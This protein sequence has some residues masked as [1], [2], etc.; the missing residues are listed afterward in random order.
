MEKYHTTMSDLFEQL[1]LASED[2]D[3]EQF[4]SKHKGLRQGVHIEDADFWSRQQAE[5]IRSSLLEDAE[6]AELIDQLNTRV[7]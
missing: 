1:G 4:I 6:W 2:S 3:I 5:F 7:R